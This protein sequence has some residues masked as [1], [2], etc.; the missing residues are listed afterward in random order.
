MLK[1]RVTKFDTAVGLGA[2]RA[3]DGVDYEFHAIELVDG[4]RSIDLGQV[5]VF[6]PLPKFGRQQAGQIRKVD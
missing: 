4:S 5:V 1:G 2:V 3:D 6:Q